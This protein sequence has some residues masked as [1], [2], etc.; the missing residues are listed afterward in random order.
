[1]GHVKNVVFFQPT[2]EPVALER[3]IRHTDWYRSTRRQAQDWPEGL[4][5]PHGDRAPRL[6]TDF[7]V[8]LQ[9][10]GTRWEDVGGGHLFPTLP[11]SLV[12]C[13]S[14]LAA[15]GSPLGSQGCQI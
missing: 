2:A 10:Q 12:Q 5:L 15:G 7:T 9:G 11:V 13:F 3:S 1:M 6:S 14:A 8:L 4:L